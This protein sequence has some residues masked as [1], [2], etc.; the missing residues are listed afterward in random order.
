MPPDVASFGNGIMPGHAQS[1]SR[2]GVSCL[3]VRML[4]IA[5]FVAMLTCAVFA[6]AAIYISFVEHPA[7]MQCDTRTAATV[8]APSYARATMMQAPLAVLSCGAGIV[9]WSLGAGV[10]WLIGALLIGSVVPF[11]LI[12]IRPTNAQLLM[13]ERDLTSAETRSLLDKWGRLHAVRSVLSLIASLLFLA[14]ILNS[15]K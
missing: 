3:E 5:E 8:W 6:G 1:R 12:V 7:R 2:L 13:Q 15:S 4:V 10:I 11:T 9:A 14:A